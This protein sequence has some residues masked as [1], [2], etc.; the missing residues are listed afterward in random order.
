MIRITFNPAKNARNIAERDLPFELVA[1]LDWAA[2]VTKDDTRRNYGELRSVVVVP[3]N[4]RL[5]VAVVTMRGDAVHVI[6]FRK[7]NKKEVRG[8]EQ[9]TGR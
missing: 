1:D 4:G 7:A 9:T 3:L 8:Y 2:A 6:N 5:H